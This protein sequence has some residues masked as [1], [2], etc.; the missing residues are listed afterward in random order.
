MRVKVCG[1]TDMEQ[2]RQLDEIGVEF[3]GFIFYPKSPRYIFKRVPAA[4]IKKVKG[5][6][7]KVGVFVNAYTDDILKTV[8]DCGLYLVQLHGD[9][10][11][12]ECEKI[13]SYVT[14]VKA[15]RL[16][17]SDNILW[18]IKDYQDVVDMFLFDTEGAG[19]GGTGKKFN[20]EVLK[21]LNIRKPFFLSGG[22]QSDDTDKLK[23]FAQDPVAKDLFSVDINSR[24]EISHGIKDVQKIKKFIADLKQ[25]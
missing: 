18:K 5:K 15:F 12:R 20:W 17:E 25:V 10:T 13:S 24:F 9:E 3:C 16:S 23:S 4:E 11:P 2:V 22:I 1:M 19:Y 6:I 14:T 21:G 8:D 7:N